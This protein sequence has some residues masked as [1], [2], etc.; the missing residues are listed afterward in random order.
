MKIK[1]K[2]GDLLDAFAQTSLTLDKKGVTSGNLYLRSED[3][4]NSLYSY[5]TNLVSETLIRVPVTVE[6]AGEVLVNPRKIVDGLAG[7]S[8][9]QEVSFSLNESKTVMTVKSGKTRFTVATDPNVAQMAAKAKTTLSAKESATKISA[10]VLAE[11]LKK[12]IFCIPNDESGQRQALSALKLVDTEETEE[13][14]ATD[15]VLAVRISSKRSANGVGLGKGVLLPAPSLPALSSL[16]NRKRGE[17][18]KVILSDTKNKIGF[19]F[20]DTFFG[21]LTMASSF[22]NLEVIFDKREEEANIFTV[23]RENLKQALSRCSSFVSSDRN[24]RVLEMEMN[25]DSIKLSANGDDSINDQID[26]TY[27]KG[28]PNGLKFGLSIDHLFNIV[29]GSKSETITIGATKNDRPIVVTDVC[30]EEED[31]ELK[32]V[33]VMMGVRVAK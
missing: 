25:R 28:E 30:N 5:S 2:V 26:V 4:T 12:T 31:E 8:R 6:T 18:A 23:D 1:T 21:S 16:L 7:I 13:A 9:E 11:I 14:Y 22:P 27:K 29:S 20:G 33:Y 3:T 32:V 24:K 15:G 19:K 17:E 10:S